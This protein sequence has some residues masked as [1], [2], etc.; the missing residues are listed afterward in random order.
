LSRFPAL[1]SA[2]LLSRVL[3]VVLRVHVLAVAAWPWV[4]PWKRWMQRGSL[5]DSGYPHAF[6]WFEH[7]KARPATSRALGVLRDEAIAGQ[8]VRDEGGMD[9]EGLK[10]MFRRDGK[11]PAS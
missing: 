5:A 11:G 10:L 8:K 9:V 7:I 6:R 4:K 1:L 2:S 3:S